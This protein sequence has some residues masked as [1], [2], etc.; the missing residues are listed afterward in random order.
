MRLQVSRKNTRV[1]CL[2][3]FLSRGAPA[4]IYNPSQAAET[5][6]T[7]EYRYEAGDKLIWIKTRGHVK[8]R[9]G[10]IVYN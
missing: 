5:K 8:N 2:S 6:S 10:E 7:L 1:R 9:S 4:D 3:V